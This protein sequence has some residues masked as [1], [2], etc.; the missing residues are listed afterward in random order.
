M[1]HYQVKLAYNIDLHGIARNIVD[2]CLSSYKSWTVCIVPLSATDSSYFENQHW[3]LFLNCHFK[4]GQEY[5]IGV[6]QS[7]KRLFSGMQKQYKWA[8]KLQ[9][10]KTEI[11]QSQ[12]L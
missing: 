7:L 5:L 4:K 1:F 9:W 2:S 11:S 6:A 10:S 8:S 3:L 12:N